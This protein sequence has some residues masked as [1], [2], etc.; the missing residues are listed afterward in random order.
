MTGFRHA[1]E[2]LG[3]EVVWVNDELSSASAVGEGSLVFAYNEACR[4][5][6][7]HPQAWYLLHNM[8]GDADLLV[9]LPAERVV[10]LQVYTDDLM[11]VDGPAWGCEQWDAYTFYLRAERPALFQPWGTDLLPDEFCEPV[12]PVA[13]D[14]VWWVGSVWDHLGQ[15]NVAM[16]GRL[17]VALVQRG[18]RFEHRQHASPEE[19]IALTRASRL[20][21]AYAGDWQALNG[22]LPCRAFKAASYGHLLITNVERFRDLLGDTFIGGDMDAQL[23]AC[24]A[25]SADEYCERVREQQRLIGRY[26]YARKLHDVFRV[27]ETTYG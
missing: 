12:C 10:L 2:R 16:I 1:A 6:P 21:P 25:M 8:G 7:S 26:S 19:N 27:L 18:L 17:K 13:S 3:K 24:L 14:V 9:R 11:T 4:Y 5:L 22:Y 23:D 15:G 20:S